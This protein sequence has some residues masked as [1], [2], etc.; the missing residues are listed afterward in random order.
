MTGPY[1]TAATTSRDKKDLLM[2][3]FDMIIQHSSE[4]DLY[5]A[6]AE[7]METIGETAIADMIKEARLESKE[8]NST[9]SVHM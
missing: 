1:S 8:S 9:C 3:L 2:D 5:E 4:D 6:A 7:M